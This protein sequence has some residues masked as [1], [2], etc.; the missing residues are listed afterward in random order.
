MLS[1]KFR[2]TCCKS[3][4]FQQLNRYII[5]ILVITLNI[6]IFSMYIVFTFFVTSAILVIIFLHLVALPLVYE[7]CVRFNLYALQF[8]YFIIL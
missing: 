5:C 6:Y 8:I 2:K 7:T 3:F 4:Y 1:P